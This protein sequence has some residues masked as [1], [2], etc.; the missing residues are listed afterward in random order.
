MRARLAGKR[1]LMHNGFMKLTEQTRALRVQSL[2]TEM[3]D[4]PKTTTELMVALGWHRP[5]VVAWLH[6]AVA[7]DKVKRLRATN[8][9][10][11]PAFRYAPGTRDDPDH[12]RL[13]D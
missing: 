7:S 5:T 13:T 1:R 10:G 2:L 12:V 6:Y 4:G 8:K 11:R 9:A 3:A